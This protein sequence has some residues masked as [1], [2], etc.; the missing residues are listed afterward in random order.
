MVQANEKS[1]FFLNQPKHSS[2][3]RKCYYKFPTDGMER[4]ERSAVITP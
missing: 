3:L 2:I 1:P 4:I